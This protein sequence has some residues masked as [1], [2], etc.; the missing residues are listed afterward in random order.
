MQGP[1]GRDEDTS[2]GFEFGGWLVP[3]FD[4]NLGRIVNGW[5][6]EADA[7]LA[8]S[9]SRTEPQPRVAFSPVRC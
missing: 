3:L 8:V 1:G 5:F 9:R 4:E 6:A 7:I 2:G